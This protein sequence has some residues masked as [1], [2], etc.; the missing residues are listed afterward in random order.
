MKTCPKCGELNGDT[1][2]KCFRCQYVFNAIENILS[3]NDVYEYD[4]VSITDEPGGRTDIKKLKFEIDSRAAKGWRL[5]KIL[6]DELGQNGVRIGGIGVNSTVDQ[7]ILIF[8][9]RIKKAD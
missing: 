3:L 2:D 7:V 6:S 5:A 1:N 4:L 8:E 9:R